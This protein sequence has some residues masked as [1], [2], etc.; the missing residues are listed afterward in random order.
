MRVSFWP[1][2]ALIS[3]SVGL[4]AGC[5]DSTGTAGAGAVRFNLA[6][7]TSAAA[8][9]ALSADVAPVTL[10]DGTNTLVINSAQIVVR[11]IELQ[12]SGADVTC[13]EDTQQEGEFETG[14][15]HGND[16]AETDDADCAELKLGPVLLD[17]PLTPGVRNAINVDLTPGDYGRAEFQ[18]HKPGG[19]NDAAFLQDHPDFRGI[20]VRVTG[21]FNDV[22]FTYNGDVTATQHL[23]L[24]PPLTVGDGGTADLT[25]FVDV[26]SWFRVDGTLINPSTALSGQPNASRVKNNIQSAFRAFGDPDRDGLDD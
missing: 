4:I 22:P 11:K 13:T 18:L 12:R 2:A 5:S 14:D 3:T 26:D 15:D 24:D 8:A 16:A 17:L 23:T 6:T 21:S 1:S 10:T 9:A 25:L 20:S 19:S 7:R